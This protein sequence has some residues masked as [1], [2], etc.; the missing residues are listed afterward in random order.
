MRMAAAT[1]GASR[2]GGYELRGV[3][4]RG[5]MGVV[6]RARQL[7]LNRPVALKMI[8]AGLWAG[9]DEVRRFKNEAEAIANL[10]H[11]QI[12]TI[13]EVGEHSGQHYFSMKL[14]EG[15]SLAERLE[16]YAAKPREAAK[17]VAEVARAVQHAHQR[18]ILHRDLKPSN[19]LLDREGRPHVTDFGLAKKLEGNGTLSVSGSIVGTPQ[20]MSPEQASGSRQAITTATD[21]YGLGALLYAAL[22]AQ[23]PFQSDSVLETLEQVRETAPTPPSGVNRK[24]PRDL[25]VICLRCLEKDPKRRYDSAAALAEE[26]ERYLRGEPILARPTSLPERAVKWVRRRPAIAALVGLVLLMALGGFAGVLWQ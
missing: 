11:P 12:V 14:V 5:G 25:E 10:D 24:V 7:S 6:H 26:L 21:V 16:E 4:G 3:L 18:G 23:P 9:G 20:Y 13:H 19:I 8:R 22:T 17:L 15:P 2:I 1:P